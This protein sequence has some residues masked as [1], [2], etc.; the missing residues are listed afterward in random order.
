[1]SLYRPQLR[2]KGRTRT[3]NATQRRFKAHQTHLNEVLLLPHPQ[4]FVALKG[5]C[6]DSGLGGVTFFAYNAKR[7]RKE[8]PTLD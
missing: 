4:H 6:G 5:I 3:Q 1:M 2:D 7:A 8:L